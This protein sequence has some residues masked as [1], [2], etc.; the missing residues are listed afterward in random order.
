MLFA[1][2][3]ALD[4][5]SLPNIRAVETFQHKLLKVLWTGPD[6]VGAKLDGVPPR[7]RRKNPTPKSG[8]VMLWMA[9]RFKGW[10][11]VVRGVCPCPAAA[12]F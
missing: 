12:L 11:L 6:S 7:M 2:V 5:G 4:I 10:P 1:F 9:T 8:A 3:L